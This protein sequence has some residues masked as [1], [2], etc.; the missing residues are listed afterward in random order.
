[1]AKVTPTISTTAKATAPATPVTSPPQVPTSTMVTPSASKL[2][3]PVGQVTTSGDWDSTDFIHSFIGRKMPALKVSGSNGISEKE[4]RD[5]F[6]KSY[7][8]E[9]KADLDRWIARGWEPTTIIGPEAFVLRKFN[10]YR[11]KNAL[12]WVIVI[13]AAIPSVGMSLIW[14]LIPSGFVEPTQFVAKL[15]ARHRT[16]LP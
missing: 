9:I 6:W 10:G 12:F 16:P 11:D 4:A 8:S 15:R 7:Q 5:L 13:I 14:G 3:A 1:M 2:Y